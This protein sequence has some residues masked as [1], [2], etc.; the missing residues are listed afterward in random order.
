MIK[1]RLY[2]DK[3]KEEEFLNNMSKRGY[4]LVDFFL[5]FYTF[6]KCEPNEYTHKVDLVRNKNKE[7]LEEYLE[8][9]KDSGVVLVRRWGPWA[10]FKKRGKFELY[11]DKESQIKQYTQIRNMFAFFSIIELICS[12]TNIIPPIIYRYP[13]FGNLFIGI[14]LGLIF[15]VFVNQVFKCNRKIKEIRQ[16]I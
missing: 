2:Y 12:C 4:E 10:I 8:L 13:Y 5:G 16:S 3:D 11:T 9:L 14:L 15:L 7:E 1:F 6:K